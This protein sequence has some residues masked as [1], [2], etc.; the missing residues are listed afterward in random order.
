MNDTKPTANAATTVVFTP[1]L[2]S[3][4]KA[5]P[6]VTGRSARGLSA[7]VRRRRPWLRPRPAA[8]GQLPAAGLT[9]RPG[10]SVA[11]APR[12]TQ[13]L[14]QRA[15]PQAPARSTLQGQSRCPTA[16]P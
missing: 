6:P 12:Q 3:T 9:G 10:G 5:A 15:A 4:C 8:L 11:S 16:W 14:L 7:D 2:A 1:L 13:S